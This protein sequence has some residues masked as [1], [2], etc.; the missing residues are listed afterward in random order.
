LG[1]SGLAGSSF[2]QQILGEN[3]MQA[4]QNIAGI[5][6]TM[7]NDFLARGVPTVVG[8]GTNALST[9]ASLNTTSRGQFTPSLFNDLLQGF[10]G[11]KGGGSG[12]SP[13][14][15]FGSGGGSSGGGKGGSSAGATAGLSSYAGD[16]IASFA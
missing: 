4:G 8:A 10:T 9:A 6:S 14:S 3:Q 15:Y 16:P 12:A 2:A 5:P 1:Q 11:G 7:T 13:G